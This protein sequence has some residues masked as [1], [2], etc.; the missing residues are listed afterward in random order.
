MKHLRPLIVSVSLATVLT[1]LF[2]LA[3]RVS[4]LFYTEVEIKNN[5]L[6]TGSVALTVTPNERLFT[7]E[8]LLPGQVVQNT[9]EV[10]N[11]GLSP[12]RLTLSAKK[13]AGYTNLYDQLRLVV[14]DQDGH[15]FYE[16]LLKELATVSLGAAPVTPQQSVTFLVSL[17]LPAE[18]DNSIDNLS[19]TITFIVGATQAS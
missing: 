1:V 12:L 19:T 14:K 16:G 18:A 2:V 11:S 10:K 13:S 3:T 7:A 5:V 15:V 9:L 4:A 17:E 6:K 8:A